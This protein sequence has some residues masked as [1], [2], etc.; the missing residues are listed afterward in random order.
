MA[1]VTITHHHADGEVTTVTV[2]VDA[3]YP[4]AIDQARAEAV[5]CLADTLC[6]LEVMWSDKG[7]DG[8]EN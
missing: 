5:H 1:S 2:E 4:D 3:D 6:I 8:A 7:D